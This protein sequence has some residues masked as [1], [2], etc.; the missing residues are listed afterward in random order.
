[1]NQKGLAHI[2]I[3]LILLA[4]L[5]ATLYL[6][7]HTQIFK[8]KAEEPKDEI[9][10]SASANNPNVYILEDD[11]T[12]DTTDGI[13]FDKT[14]GL[15]YKTHPDKNNLY[16]FIAIFPSFIPINE[17][18][19]YGGLHSE[20]QNNVRGIC[21]PI[22]IADQDFWGSSKLQGIQIYPYSQDNY[23]NWIDNP[24]LAGKILS[25][26]T[27]HQWLTTLGKLHHSVPPGNPPDGL[28]LSCLN[29]NIPLLFTDS[30]HWSEGLQM[31]PGNY[32]AMREAKPW[33]DNGDGTFSVDTSLDP[34]YGGP[35][36]K[37]HPFDLY[38]MGLTSKS[39]ITGSY[40][41][42]SNMRPATDATKE[43]PATNPGLVRADAQ[44]VTIDDIIR[45]AGEERSPDVN[46]S[47]KD[48][49]IAFVILTKTGQSAPQSLVS[50]INAIANTFPAQWAYATNYLSTMNS[51]SALVTPTPFPSPTPTPTPAPV[52]RCITDSDCGDGMR[53][54]LPVCA[55]PDPEQICR[56]ATDKAKCFQEV[57]QK[58]RQR[59]AG[60]CVKAPGF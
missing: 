21:Y 48:F 56:E 7:Q 49:K 13:R 32:G 50:A 18:T 20:A 16:D 52:M 14:T 6:S 17:P 12:I 57:E 29:S 15:F 11:G 45:I 40:L 41:L 60:R 8:P 35:P 19:T 46:H 43:H 39:E 51:E 5:G 28:N 26:E 1:M 33:V 27:S 58:A 36:A 47:Q 30:Q 10:N 22:R 34:L 31:P 24:N 54:Q 9:I 42:L 3:I 23:Q 55:N 4:G 25:E 2:L 53:C 44:R 59:C 38:L 37:F